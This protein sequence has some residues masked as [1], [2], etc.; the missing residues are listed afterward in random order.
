MIYLINKNIFLVFGHKKSMVYD[1]T[2]KYLKL[3]WLDEV[4]T[5]ILKQYFHDKKCSKYVSSIKEKIKLNENITRKID[6]SLK[7][8]IDYSLFG[9]AWVEITNICNFKCIHCYGSFEANNH[10]I[11]SIK[12]ILHIFKELKSIGIKNIQL[13][14]GEP[15]LHPDIIDILKYSKKYFNKV[16]IFTNGYFVDDKI[17]SLFSDYDISVAM[18]A[19]SHEEVIHNTVT[20]NDKSYKKLKDAISILNKYSIQYRLAYVKMKHNYKST[21]K[22]ISSSL[23]CDCNIK[24]DPIRLVGRS[25]IDH[26]NND[27]LEEKYIKLYNFITPPNNNLKHVIIRAW[28]K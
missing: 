3:I 10:G 18:S 24:Q 6:L 11:L 7:D 13:I 4:E 25:S 9:F 22:D 2:E 12:E 15:L 5:T 20:G 26:Y 28:K 8:S 19:Y 14:G 23:G 21:I 27:L 17:A 16:E 1:I